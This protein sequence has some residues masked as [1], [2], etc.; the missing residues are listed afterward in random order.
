MPE[1]GRPSIPARAVAQQLAGRA[2]ALA[3]EL[4][5]AGHREGA[6]WVAPSL[7]GASLRGLSVRI[8][9]S[10]AGLWGEFDSDRRG[11]AL[12]LVAHVLFRGDRKAAYRWAL[13]WLGIAHAGAAPQPQP[14]PAAPRPAPDAHERASAAA[15]MRL[16]LAGRPELRGTPADAYLKARGIDLGELGRQPRALRFHHAVRCTEAGCDLPAMLAAIVG[17]DGG[18]VATHRTFLAEHDGAWCKARL[19]APKKVLGSYTGGTI[20]L[21]RG[22][23]GKPLDK[24]PEA[25]TVAIGEGIETCLSVAIACPE[26]RVLAAASLSNLGRI[27]LPPNAIDLV[28]LADNDAGNPAAQAALARAVDRL[29]A[30]G[31]SVRIARSSTGKDFNDGIKPHE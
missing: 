10:K 17:P 1:T 16:W 28:I 8:T 31:R 15:A 12:D 30:E 14:R 29:L 20:R 6:E 22:A 2:E 21:W 4:L 11:D 7:M 27:V 13:S 25:D 26:Y 3:R 23:S 18:H 5:P 24:A 9:G 19:R